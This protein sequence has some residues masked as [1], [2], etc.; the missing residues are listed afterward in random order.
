[1]QQIS[2]YKYYSFVIGPPLG[3]GPGRL[4]YPPPLNLPLGADMITSSI[5]RLKAIHAGDNVRISIPV[6]DSA[7]PL[8][9]Q[10]HWG[11]NEGDLRWVCIYDWHQT[12]HTFNSLILLRYYTKQYDSTITP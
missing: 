10:F 8:A 3:S 5:K 4:P 2:Q 6:V 11:R 1:M 7:P 9:D 12:W